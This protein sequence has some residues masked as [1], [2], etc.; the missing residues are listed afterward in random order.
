MKISEITTVVTGGTPNTKN[1]AF[2][3]NGTIPWLQSG[4]CKNGYVDACSKYITK[5]GLDNSSAKMMPSGTVIIAL[6][7]A[8]VGK[9]AMHVLISLLR[10]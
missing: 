7:G 4:V 3:E 8:T 5:E 1:K 6:T 9:V 10:V 2:W